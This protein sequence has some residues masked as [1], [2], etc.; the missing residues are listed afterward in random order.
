MS[1]TVKIQILQTTRVEI[2]LLNKEEVDLITSEMLPKFTTIKDFTYIFQP[3]EISDLGAF[4]VISVL[5]N[6]WASLTIEFKVIVFNE[7]PIFGNGL[8]VITISRNSRQ[9][10]RIPEVKDPEVAGVVRLGVREVGKSATP[11]FINFDQ[12]TKMITI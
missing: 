10:I 11:G 2:P 6:Q 9:S 3:K 12:G 7:A 4:R 8:E 1:K 5:K